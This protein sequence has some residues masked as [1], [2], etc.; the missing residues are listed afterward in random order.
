MNEL[1][2]DFDV[3]FDNLSHGMIK[4]LD[5]QF[6]QRM[7]W[8]KRWKDYP[9]S[10]I[11]S[12]LVK[13]NPI[14]YKE[15]W[16]YLRS[17]YNR[18]SQSWFENGTEAYTNPNLTRDFKYELKLLNHKPL[19]TDLYKAMILLKKEHYLSKKQ[20]TILQT[21]YEYKSIRSTGRNARIDSI[22]CLRSLRH[23]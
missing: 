16:Y 10:S 7:I 18:S 20:E 13:I 11:S 3:V 1:N 23:G 15:G 17:G 21:D 9:L 22:K 19:S 12:G 6:W 14:F 8:D 5:L 4:R 2:I